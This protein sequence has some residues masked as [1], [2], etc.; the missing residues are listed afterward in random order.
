M[1][2]LKLLRSSPGTATVL[3][4]QLVVFIAVQFAP[5][6]SERL[7]LLRGLDV[8]QGRYLGAIVSMMAH[9]WV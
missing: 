3:A 7:F 2:F 8:L 5:P 6:G 4:V 9:A 1:F